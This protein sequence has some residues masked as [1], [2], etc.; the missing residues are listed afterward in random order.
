MR[1][2]K[3]VLLVA[4]AS[5]ASGCASTGTYTRT[6]G[7]WIASFKESQ[8]V[9]SSEKSDKRGEACSQNI[10]GVAVGDSSIEAAKKNGGI[11]RVSSADSEV[12]NILHLY[13][14]HCTIVFGS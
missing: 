4:I 5:F 12:T 2:L 7:G 3:L 14:K 1:H 8:S 10:L 13:G 6:G 9:T 11:T